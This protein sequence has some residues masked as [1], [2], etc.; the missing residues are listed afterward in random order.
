MP[1]SFIYYLSNL[2]VAEALSF[3]EKWGVNSKK[4]REAEL[5]LCEPEYFGVQKPNNFRK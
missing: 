2:I 3:L 4:A 1:L 5:M